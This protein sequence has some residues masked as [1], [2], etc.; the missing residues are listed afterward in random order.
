MKPDLQIEVKARLGEFQLD[1]HLAIEHGPVALVGPNGS[2]KTTLLRTLAG[3]IAPEEGRVRIGDQ[4]IF[5]SRAHIFLPPEARQV[6]YLPQGYGLF[7]HLSALD[8]VAYGLHHLPRD[9]RN[10]R[11]RAKLEALG[12]AHV[13][14]RRPRHLSGGERQRVALARALVTD[15]RLLLL[16]EPT[17]ALDVSIRRDT[18]I[19]LANHLGN[20]ERMSV[21]VTHDLRDLLAWDPT[22]V[23]LDEGRVLATGTLRALQAQ[24][25]H[26]FLTE[27]LSPVPTDLASSGDAGPPPSDG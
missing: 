4:V 8:N 15:P 20:P 7:E 10:H 16:D 14:S 27:F 6:G 23:L 24:V 22:V 26:P 18:R 2:G 3:A 19:R 21:V 9:E 5:D 12:I 13:A 25:D 17:A 1:V 11:A